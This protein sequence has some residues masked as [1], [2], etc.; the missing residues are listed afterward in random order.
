MNTVHLKLV[1]DGTSNVCSSAFSGPFL[2]R[3]PLGVHAAWGSRQ[4]SIFAYARLN[5]VCAQM[6]VPRSHDQSALGCRSIRMSRRQKQMA[7]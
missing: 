6:L 1:W 7:S 3:G 4:T 2:Y 5:P